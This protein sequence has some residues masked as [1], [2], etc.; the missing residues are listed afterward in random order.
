MSRLSRRLVDGTDA[1][2][3]SRRW[4]Q[5]LQSLATWL[6]ASSLPASD[7]Q[8][9]NATFSIGDARGVSFDLADNVD[10]RVVLSYDSE[11]AEPQVVV[12]SVWQGED[13]AEDTVA[14]QQAVEMSLGNRASS[15]MIKVGPLSPADTDPAHHL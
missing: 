6:T 3:S 15:L 11:I 4:Q 8:T 2:T 1:W 13:S 14:V 7:L 9:A 12:E 10:G 5:S